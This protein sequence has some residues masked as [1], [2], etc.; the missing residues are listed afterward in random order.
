[1][2]SAQSKSLCHHKKVGAVL[3]RKHEVPETLVIDTGCTRTLLT[4][5]FKKFAVGN[6]LGGRQRVLLG[7]K[8]HELVADSQRFV[9][10]PVKDT[11]GRVQIMK[12]HSAFSPDV[13]CP[14]LACSKKGI[15]KGVDGQP[16]AV[17]VDGADGKQHWIPIRYEGD[18]PVIITNYEKVNAARIDGAISQQARCKS[19]SPQEIAVGGGMRLSP[20]IVNAMDANMCAEVLKLFHLRLAHATGRRLY[21]TLKE[22]GWEG[23]FKEKECS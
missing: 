9:H 18:L 21:L 22:K 6:V 14:L 7:G 8:K 13:R 11:E 23:V 4:P 19:T 15:I 5:A 2:K 10:I 12:E 20:A 1:M 16:E 3:Q 17:R